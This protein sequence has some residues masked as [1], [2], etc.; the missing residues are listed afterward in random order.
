MADTARRKPHDH[1]HDD[2]DQRI[3]TITTTRRAVTNTARPVRVQ[4]RAQGHLTIG[5]KLGASAARQEARVRERDPRAGHDHHDHDHG[6]GGMTTA[7]VTR[8]AT[9]VLTTTAMLTPRP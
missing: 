6:N 7:A 5:K 1:G 2:H 3:R 9:T 4:A 8:T